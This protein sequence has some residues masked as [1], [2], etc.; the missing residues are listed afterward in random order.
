MQTA[1][2]LKISG[3]DAFGKVSAHCKVGACI[4]NHL[5]EKT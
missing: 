2:R 5:L 4:V 3:D 1:F